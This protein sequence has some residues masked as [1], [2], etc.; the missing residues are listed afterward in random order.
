LRTAGL[1]EAPAYV[2][3]EEIFIG[4][5]HLPMIEWLITGKAGPA[6]V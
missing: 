6:P 1:V 3:G 4:R 2:L 5:A